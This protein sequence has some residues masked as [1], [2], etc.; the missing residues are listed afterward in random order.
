[1]EMIKI[2]FLG[3]KL[4]KIVKIFN[5]NPFLLAPQIDQPVALCEQEEAQGIS[6]V[7]KFDFSL[8]PPS[9]RNV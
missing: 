7:D 5:S 3:T 9:H 4:L 6:N 1:M 8:P 2:A